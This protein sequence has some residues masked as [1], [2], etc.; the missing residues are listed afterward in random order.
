MTNLFKKAILCL[1]VLSLIG[2]TIH[3]FDEAFRFAPRLTNLL[4]AVDGSRKDGTRLLRTV[5]QPTRPQIVTTSLF[6]QGK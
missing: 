6:L 5:T 3:R 4:D 1:N 2:H